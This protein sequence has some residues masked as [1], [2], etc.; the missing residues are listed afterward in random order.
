M[1]KFVPKIEFIGYLNSNGFTEPN[2]YDNR[3][4]LRKQFHPGVRMDVILFDKTPVY[5][6]RAFLDLG[7]LFPA[8]KFP[9][10]GFPKLV[11]HQYIGPNCITCLDEDHFDLDRFKEIYEEKREDLNRVL[12]T[13]RKIPIF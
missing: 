5:E 10:E 2:K 7:L 3:R 9:D 11:G 12:E 6:M 13:V 8:L 4:E 1:T